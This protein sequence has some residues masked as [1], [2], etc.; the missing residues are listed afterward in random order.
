MG[1]VLIAYAI[2]TLQL[3]AVPNTFGKGQ[4]AQVLSSVLQQVVPL[5][6]ATVSLQGTSFSEDR[7]SDK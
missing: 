1:W 6:H 4:Q 5:A 2:I 3:S 7:K